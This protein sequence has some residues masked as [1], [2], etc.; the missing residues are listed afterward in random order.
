MNRNPLHPWVCCLAAVVLLG[1]TGSHRAAGESGDSAYGIRGR[2]ILHQSGSDAEW[3]RLLD[4]LVNPSAPRVSDRRMPVRTPCFLR[5]TEQRFL[6][7]AER[8]LLPDA[9][10]GGA[11]F[12][13]LTVPEAAQGRSLYGLY[14]DLGYSAESV[15]RQRGVAMA[16]VVF[17]Y[18][19]AVHVPDPWTAPTGMNWES[20]V[21]QPTWDVMFALFAR[22]AGET[23]DGQFSNFPTLTPQE[24]DLARFLPESRRRAVAEVP[25]ALLRMSAGADWEYRSLLMRCL[26]LND[27]FSG[28]G[29]TE[30]TLSPGDDRRGL[31]E[32]VGPDWPLS[33]LAAWAIVEFGSLEF[34]EVHPPRK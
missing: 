9:H 26:S 25:Y 8:G 11:P 4:A 7:S 34:E 16:A 10:L 32:F 3:Q 30:N 23:K 24:R 28:N 6:W 20:R 29:F 33:E 14:S 21:Y 13:F 12:V 31:P 22:L 5:L 15:L 27:H 1:L 19:A 18:P 2:R 17:R